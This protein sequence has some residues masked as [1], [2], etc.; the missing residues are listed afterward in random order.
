[1]VLIGPNYEPSNISFEH[2]SRLELQRPDAP[3]VSVFRCLFLLG[4]AMD[5][6]RGSVR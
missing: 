2:W 6:L 5:N 3:V 4:A 1:M